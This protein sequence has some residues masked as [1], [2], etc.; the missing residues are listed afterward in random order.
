M[1]SIILTQSQIKTLNDIAQKFQ[2][3]SQFEIVEKSES[4]IGPSVYIKFDLF[5]K[6]VEIDN[7]DVSNW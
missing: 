3:I 7:T 5:G 2:D 1:S 4:G 6:N